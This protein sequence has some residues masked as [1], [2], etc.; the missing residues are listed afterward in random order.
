M[1]FKGTEDFRI[2]KTSPKKNVIT[3]LKAIPQQEFQKMFLKMA[4]LLG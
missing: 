1:Y 4:A 3:T 2:L